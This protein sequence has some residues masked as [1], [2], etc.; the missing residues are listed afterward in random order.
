ML[1]HLIVAPDNSRHDLTNAARDSWRDFQAA[2]PNHPLV[3]IPTDHEPAWD[4]SV[5]EAVAANIPVLNATRDAVERGG[6]AIGAR[7]WLPDYSP[8]DRALTLLHESIHLR[9][10][11]TM[12]ARTVRIEAFRRN[13]MA[14]Q[15]A[16]NARDAPNLAVFK[17]RRA[18]AAFQFLVF[19]DEVWA[20]LD[21]RDRYPDWFERRL[22]L[23]LRMRERGRARY[24]DM[25]LS[26][27]PSLYTSWLIL[28][29]LRVDLVIGLEHDPSRLA[30]LEG[31]KREWLTDLHQMCPPDRVAVAVGIFGGGLPRPLVSAAVSEAPFDQY[32][33][34]VLTIAPV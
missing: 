20:E 33:A 26:T 16:V 19:P 23:L 22:Q 25:L 6:I 32:A 24:Q 34:E 14:I 31:L 27:P 2:I 4:E 8:D 5:S 13:Q 30:R 7:F 9:L 10:A 17:H 11:D 12:S 15:R 3:G 1:R 29:A 21:L 18:M 28:E